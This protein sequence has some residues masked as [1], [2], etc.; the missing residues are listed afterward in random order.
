MFCI[1]SSDVV[2]SLLRQRLEETTNEIKSLRKT[3]AALLELSNRMRSRLLHQKDCRKLDVHIEKENEMEE[4]EKLQYDLTR[5]E[6]EFAQRKSKLAEDSTIPTKPNLSKQ[7]LKISSNDSMSGL[8]KILDDGCSVGSEDQ[9][10]D[11]K[12][13]VK[14]PIKKLHKKTKKPKIRNYNIKSD[15]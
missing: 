3:N 5:K 14:A 4:M 10:I 2:V 1:D 6:L 9:K 13:P 7:L 15:S 11:D 8:W 12:L